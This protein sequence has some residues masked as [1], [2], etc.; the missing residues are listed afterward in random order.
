MVGLLLVD[1]LILVVR[2]GGPARLVLLLA[3]LQ[4]KVGIVA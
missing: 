3:P 1:E 4:V 2:V